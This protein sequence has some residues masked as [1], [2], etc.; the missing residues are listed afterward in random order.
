VQIKNSNFA[1][2]IIGDN[3][4][5]DN[6]SCGKTNCVCYNGFEG[7]IWEGERQRSVKIKSKE[8]NKIKTVI[9]VTEG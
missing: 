7:S 4:K 3:S 2:G 6:F 9:N 5:N 8:G 1:V